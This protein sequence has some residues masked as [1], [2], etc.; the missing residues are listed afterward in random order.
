MSEILTPTT[1][2]FIIHWGELGERWGINR[3]VAQIQALLLI[4]P[5][6]INAEQISQVLSVARS[7][8]SVGLHELQ[9]WGIINV[10]HKLGD[11]TDYYESVRDV[12]EMFRSIADRRVQNELNPTLLMIRETV[13]QLSDNSEEA[14]SKKRLTELE[15][16]LETASNLYEQIQKI[17]T[18]T[19]VKTAKIGDIVRK[20]LGTIPD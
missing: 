19:I 3:T 11:R 14:Y 9:N 15:D 8:V 4:S 6:P 2:N 12:W 13:D 20:I 7:T 16:A 17:P 18:K 10:V 1:M 5:E